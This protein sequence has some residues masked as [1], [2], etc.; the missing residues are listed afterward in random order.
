MST[1]F[2]YLWRPT[3]SFFSFPQLQRRNPGRDLRF[4]HHLDDFHL[5][6]GGP[7]TVGEPEHRRMHPETERE[8]QVQE[9]DCENDDCRGC[10]LCCMLASLPCLLLVGSSFALIITVSNVQHTYLSIYWLAMSNSMYNPI[11]YCWMNS[12]FRQGFKNVFFLLQM[13][14]GTCQS[15]RETQPRH[16][17]P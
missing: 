7:R 9:E 3:D 4:A 15:F 17:S 2:L 6:Q 1:L 16:C 14:R 10:D 8:R 11:I 12:R 13:E 5:L